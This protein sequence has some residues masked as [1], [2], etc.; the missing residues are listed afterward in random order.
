MSS[1]PSVIITGSGGEGVANT[2]LDR[3]AARNPLFL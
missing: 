2:F 3:K 1:C